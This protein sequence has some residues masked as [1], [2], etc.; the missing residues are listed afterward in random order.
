MTPQT[1]EVLMSDI[2]ASDPLDFSDLAIGED[3]ARSLMA[4]HFCQLDGE[5]SEA[6]LDAE[7]RL[8]V[9]TAIAA[10]TMEANFLIHVQR[11]RGRR[12]E[13]FDLKRWMAIRGFGG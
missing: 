9:M 4:H 10:H 12:H 11:L 13:G 1:L 5:L 8:A 7:G 2:E 6:G 3:D